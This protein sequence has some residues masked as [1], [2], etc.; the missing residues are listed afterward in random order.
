MNHR[1]ERRC[2]SCKEMKN[3][4]KYF[5]FTDKGNRRV[6][7]N[8]CTDKNRLKRLSKTCIFCKSDKPIESFDLLPSGQRYNRCND[9][10]PAVRKMHRKANCNSHRKKDTK[11]CRKC[12][13]D[14]LKQY[15]SFTESGILHAYCNSCRGSKQKTGPSAKKVAKK[16]DLVINANPNSLE[17]IQRERLSAIEVLQKA[18]QREKEIINN[19]GRFIKRGIRAY[20]LTR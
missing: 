10:R 3:T 6:T 7:C 1:T 15:F 4:E 9:C 8:E 17:M 16:D 12:R 14:K 18:K 13:K 5:G 19:G 11:L 20:V 2:M